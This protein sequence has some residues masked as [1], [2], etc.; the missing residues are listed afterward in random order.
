MKLNYYLTKVLQVLFILLA[1]VYV[2][3]LSFLAGKKD[4]YREFTEEECWLD[5]NRE[6]VCFK[7]I[8]D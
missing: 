1:I 3:Y 8:G 6:V 7:Y 2:C 4:S 5:N